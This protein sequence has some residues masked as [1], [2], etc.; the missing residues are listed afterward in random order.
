MSELDQD[1]DQRLD[2]SRSCSVCIIELHPAAVPFH[3]V[4]CNCRPSSESVNQCIKMLTLFSS[5]GWSLTKEEFT[6]FLNATVRPHTSNVASN[7]TI[8]SRIESRIDYR[9]VYRLAGACAESK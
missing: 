7:H 8:E 4:L 3:V 5:S 6:K 1:W 9:K 2:A